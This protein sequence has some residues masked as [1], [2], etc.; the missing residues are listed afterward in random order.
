V[1]LSSNISKEFISYEMKFKLLWNR[2]F[3]KSKKNSTAVGSK[4]LVQY[5]GTV[6]NKGETTR[7]K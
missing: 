5:S 1:Q 2:G 7:K 4:K 3:K 6:S